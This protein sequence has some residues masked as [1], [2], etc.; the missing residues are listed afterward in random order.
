MKGNSFFIAGLVPEVCDHGFFA[1]S[2]AFVRDQG[3]HAKARS[4]EVSFKFPTP[5]L[6]SPRSS[7]WSHPF[8]KMV[9]SS[10]PAW[11]E[12]LGLCQGCICLSLQPLRLQAGPRVRG[13]P[14]AGR[15]H[16]GPAPGRTSLG[17]SSDGRRRCGA[18]E[19]VLLHFIRRRSC[20]FFQIA[21]NRADQI[22]GLLSWI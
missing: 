1:P 18:W 13:W 10:G 12:G 17:P 21:V 22:D 4:C 14:S 11:C 9:R 6:S 3:Y 19:I 20:A 15:G 8:S 2:M 7:G 16:R 5:P